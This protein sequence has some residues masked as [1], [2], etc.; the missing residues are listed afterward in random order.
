MKL[1]T[2]LEVMTL[3][4]SHLVRSTAGNLGNR[5]FQ[6]IGEVD[7]ALKEHPK[8]NSNIL[9]SRVGKVYRKETAGMS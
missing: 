1:Y 9:C 6:I 4:R 8:A 2:K 7:F 5:E 3:L